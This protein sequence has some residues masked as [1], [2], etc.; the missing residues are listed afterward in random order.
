LR[1]ERTISQEDERESNDGIV[2]GSREGHMKQLCQRQDGGAVVD[3]LHEPVQRQTI[4]GG[5][6]G[7]VSS[8]HVICWRLLK[9]RPTFSST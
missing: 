1:S 5:V 3:D 4:V 8:I 9:S 6:R 7:A 2:S